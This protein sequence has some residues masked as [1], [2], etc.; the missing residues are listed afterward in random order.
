MY[1]V[2]QVDQSKGFGVFSTRN[3][4]A[5]ETVICE[6]PILLYPQ[7]SLVDNVCSHC[8]R[9]LHGN[10]AVVKC[11]TCDHAFFCNDSC[12]HASRDDPGSHSIFV[13]NALSTVSSAEASD[14]TASALHLLCRVYGLLLAACAS[15]SSEAMDRFHAFQSLSPGNAT[16]ILLDEDYV[17]WLQ[18]V[19]D[20]FLPFLQ[21][22]RENFG[23]I[24]GLNPTSPEFVREIFLKDLVNAYGIRAP[25]RMGSDCTLIRGTAVYKEC[26]RIN[27]E[28]LP[29]IARCEDFDE[30]SGNNVC[31]KFKALHDLPP[32]EEM[33]QSYFPL[34]WD[35]EERQTRCHQV[36][37]FQCTCPRCSCES[38]GAVQN[39]RNEVAEEGYISVFLM[40]YLCLEDECEGTMVPEHGC[41]QKTHTCNVCCKQR[42]EAQF[43][44]ML[45]N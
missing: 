34:A 39:A 6:K 33:T 28:C 19:Y 17:S 37:G 14:E 30:T 23:Q 4:T 27:H 35:L 9:D 5:G 1:S 26:S 15:T 12:L 20:R 32:G 2:K 3:I 40:K 41:P 18:N 29:N 8:L 25:L 13:C 16:V 7:A 42:T 36:Y 43:L 11:T 10:P 21:T 38:G 22:Q 45:G 24:Q 31:M 44:A